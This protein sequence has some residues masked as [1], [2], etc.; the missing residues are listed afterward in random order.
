MF[1][2]A[3][4]PHF[5]L[6]AALREHPDWRDIPIGLLD[7]APS[8]TTKARKCQI[9]Q[10]NREAQQSG[11]SEGMT[12]PQGQARCSRIR[13]LT[14]APVQE[15]IA[16]DILLQWNANITPNIEST[17]SGVCTVN[18]RGT[19]YDKGLEERWAHAC[20]KALT[21]LQLRPQIGIANTPDLALLAAQSAHTIQKLSTQPDIIQEFL[22]PF[23]ISALGSDPEILSILQRWGIK[24][25]GTL[26]K[27]PK[28]E[29]VRRL[30]KECLPIWERAQGKANRPL[31]HF[32]PSCILTE[33]TELEQAIERLEALIFILNRFL[34]QLT[35]RLENLYRVAAS[36]TLDL[37]FDDGTSHHKNFRIPEP[38]RESQRLFRMLFT[39]L[40][41][42]RSPSPIIGLSLSISPTR[43][44]HVQLSLFETNLRDPN[45]FTETLSQL[46]AILGPNRVGTPVPTA[47]H[48]PD[49]FQLEPFSTSKPREET[50][51]DT[52]PPMDGLPLRRFRPPKPAHITLAQST[53]AEQRMRI[54][55]ENQPAVSGKMQ[56]PWKNSGHWWDQDQWDRQE[57]DVELATGGLYRIAYEA[58]QWLVDGIYD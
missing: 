39:Y 5:E 2:V 9:I 54:H 1:G 43:S 28:Q 44:T 58:D 7:E 51:P 3:Y 12:A 20:I 38:T 29:V 17:R 49:S 53:H 4:I 26:V 27:L 15:R 24:N 36:M 41:N 10:A 33:S 48:R 31:H 37:R 21:S 14:R 25:V 22:S 50:S 30:G 52:Q 56:G 35:A 23:P 18:L 55:F 34:D 40:E 42:L 47:S 45:R 13:L 57:W 32:Q 8:G 19:S 6:Q 11:V 46:E 16:Q